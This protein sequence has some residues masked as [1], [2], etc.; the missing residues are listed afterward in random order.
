M[1]T[2]RQP[3]IMFEVNPLSMNAA[4]ISR[5][6][7]IQCLQDLGYSHYVEIH[8]LGEPRKLERLDATRQRNIIFVSPAQRATRLAVPSM[9]ASQKAIADNCPGESEIEHFCEKRRLVPRAPA[10]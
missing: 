8:A 1:V 2:S 5:V 9:V 4:G 6:A 3:H 7:I 10:G